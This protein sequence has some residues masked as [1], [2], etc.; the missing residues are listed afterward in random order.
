MSILSCS[1]A[2]TTCIVVRCA[3]RSGT[4]RKL[5]RGRGR[6]LTNYSLYKSLNHYSRH[7]NSA[8]VPLPLPW[9][10]RE[11]RDRLTTIAS[12]EL[13]K[14]VDGR[15][16]QRISSPSPCRKEKRSLRPCLGN[17]CLT[18]WCPTHLGDIE[19]NTTAPCPA[20]KF[21]DPWSPPGPDDVALW[22]TSWSP[23]V[24]PIF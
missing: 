2:L 22:A 10:T 16:I 6:T 19:I 5:W 20:T 7:R 1:S 15:N 18:Q 3:M 4:Y 11:P 8:W 23:L 17:A 14:Y 13:K 12:V 9:S 24:Q 21:L